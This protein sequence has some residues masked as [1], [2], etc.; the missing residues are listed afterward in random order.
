MSE[1]EPI[2]RRDFVAGAAVAAAG[3]AATGLIANP[4]MAGH[5]KKHK[6]RH[7]ICVFTKPFQ[8]L[9]YNELAERIAELGFDGIEG[10]IRKG[11]HI[12][13]EAVPD[14]L[15]KMV[16][17]LTKHGLKMTVM[18]TSINSVDKVNEAQ[19]RTAAELGIKQYRMYYYKYNLKKPLLDQLKEFRKPLDELAALNAE[20]GIS[21]CYQNHSGAQYVGSPIWDLRYLLHE[22]PREQVGVAFDIR[23][24]TIEGGTAWEA[25]FQLIKDWLNVVYVKDAKWVDGNYKAVNVPLGAPDARVNP[26]FFDIL[27]KSGFAGP[28]SL[29]EEYLDHRKPELVPD[30]LKAIAADFKTLKGWLKS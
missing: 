16:E 18:T 22:I 11:G 30:H 27:A 26:K 1:R 12:E 9:S 8:S 19:L 4:A 24:A 6:T 14:E 28:V 17:A 25:N 7:E 2:S 5:H 13:P 10:T 15:P 3:A 29:H 23:H 21:A 20:L